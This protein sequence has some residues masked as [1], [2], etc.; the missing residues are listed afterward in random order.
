M[1]TLDVL[2]SY[3]GQPIRNICPNGYD[4]GADNHCAHFVAHV[5]QLDF[6]LTCAKMR[7]GSVGANVRVQELFDRCPQPRE[8]LE[9]PTTGEGLIF[10]SAATSFHGM[11]VRIRNVPRKHVGLVMNGTVWHYSNRRSQVVE[12]TVGEFLFHYP[13]QN[14]A[15]WWGNFP[16]GSRPASCGTSA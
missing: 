9:C 1:L 10:V 14:N 16:P 11:P 3:M 2:K 7:H 13:R 6:G 8:V 12:Q 5:L 15:L 4:A